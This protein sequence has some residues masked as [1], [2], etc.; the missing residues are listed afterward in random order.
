MFRLLPYAQHRCFFGPRILSRFCD[1]ASL[2]PAGFLDF[3][4]VIMRKAAASL[5]REGFISGMICFMTMPLHSLS[6]GFRATARRPAAVVS[7][8][9]IP[10]PPFGFEVAKKEASRTFPFRPFR[11]ASNDRSVSGRAHPARR[12]YRAARNR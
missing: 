11:S 3:L 4:S 12:G 1:V 10:H 9:M 6:S 2:S 5:L 7:L 8:V